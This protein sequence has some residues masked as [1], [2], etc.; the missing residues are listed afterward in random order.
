MKKSVS[1]VLI[2]LARGM[3]F[4]V[5]GWYDE[6]LTISEVLISLARGM[7]FRGIFLNGTMKIVL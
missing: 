3:L 7:L 5:S 4:R 6:H 2:S 1:I